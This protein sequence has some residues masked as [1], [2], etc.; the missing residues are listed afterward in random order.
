MNLTPTT[1]HYTVETR[2]AASSFATGDGAS[3]VSTQ[4]TAS[5]TGSAC[6]RLFARTSYALSRADHV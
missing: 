5:R 3:P 2:L 6:V 4:V 1:V